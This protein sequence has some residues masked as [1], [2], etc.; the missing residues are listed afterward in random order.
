MKEK[1]LNECDNIKKWFNKDRVT[2]FLCTIFLGFIAHIVFITGNIATQDSL[3][4]GFAYSKPGSWEVSLGRWGILLVER[5]NNFVMIPSVVTTLDIILI[6][7]S[8]VLI[9]DIF[10]FKNKIS[11]Y[12]TMLA[13]ILS[14][15]I[16]IT[17]FYIHTAIAYS[18]ALLFSTISIW[19]LYKFKYK[20]IGIIISILC[21]AFTLAL[22]QSYIGVM[23]GICIMYNVISLLKDEI[24]LK[25]ILKN[26]G[27]AILV[28]IIGAVLYYAV[29][30][31]IFK[32]FNVS[33]SAYNGANKI[34]LLNI[35]TNLKT[36]IPSCYSRFFDYFINDN[37]FYNTNYRRDLLWIIFGI[38]GLIALICKIFKIKNTSKHIK[39]VKIILAII[40]VCLIPV[41]LNIINVIVGHDCIYALTAVQTILIVPF[42]LAILENVHTINILFYLDVLLLIF[43]IIT[44][45]VAGSTSYEV[46]KYTYNQSIMTTERII[47]RIESLDDYEKGMGVV[48]A[49]I[50]DPENFERTSNLYNFSLGFCANNTVFHG[51]YVGQNGTWN[52][53]L[54]I[55]F[56]VQYPVVS[57]AWYTNIINNEEFKEM[58]VFPA[59]DSVKILEGAVVVKLKQ[60]PSTP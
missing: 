11:N 37:L 39:I 36:T 6:A 56:G 55:F 42:I 48:F 18:F 46:M 58:E 2:L 9:C 19:F 45:F 17:F 35:F 28:V 16:Y 54:E 7:V 5:L 3:W 12:L 47:S 38:I 44:F 43:I 31:A 34:S 49:G 20:K 32:V 57:D 59:Q 22:Y 23:V 21:F 8:V 14:P 15:A 51:D 50:I 41:G 13:V 30:N 52:R 24:T 33:L 4:L 10:D 40:F 53:F 1:I 29:T 25:D 26:I 27:I 60:N